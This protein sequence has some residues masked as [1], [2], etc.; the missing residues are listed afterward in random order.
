MHAHGGGT[1]RT[2]PCLSVTLHR[3]A[4]V[5]RKHRTDLTLLPRLLVTPPL[6]GHH[7]LSAEEEVEKSSLFLVLFAWMALHK[8][9]I[10][11]CWQQIRNCCQSHCVLLFGVFRPHS[12]G[13]P[14]RAGN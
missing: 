11:S 7:K 4:A 14:T 6:R 9:L 12:Q 5:H 10:K 8:L 3:L 1:E 2:Q 13:F